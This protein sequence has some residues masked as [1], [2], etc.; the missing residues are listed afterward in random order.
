MS[1]TIGVGSKQPSI[2]EDVC[3]V[4]YWVNRNVVLD[5]LTTLSW[6]DLSAEEFYIVDSQL[7]KYQQFFRSEDTYALLAL[8][9]VR[10]SAALAFAVT[11][12]T[13]SNQTMQNLIHR[14]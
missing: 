5:Y 13:R 14:Q 3:D 4:A 6:S 7:T 11:T 1:F 2:A 12:L 9:I 10:R 8:D